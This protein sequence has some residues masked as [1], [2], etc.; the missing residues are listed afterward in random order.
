MKVNYLAT[1][2]IAKCDKCGI[3]LWAE[4]NDGPAPTAMPCPISGCKNQSDAKLLQFPVSSTGSP[5]ALIT[6]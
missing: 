2:P 3:N 5:I 4:H 1:R 6:G